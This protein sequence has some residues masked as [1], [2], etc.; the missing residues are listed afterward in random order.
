MKKYY[1]NL[2]YINNC[3]NLTNELILPVLPKNF[4]FYLQ[5]INYIKTNT[6]QCHFCKKIGEKNG[7]DKRFSRRKVNKSTYKVNYCDNIFCE[8][9]FN[10]YKKLYNQFIKNNDYTLFKNLTS[11]QL[12]Y[13]NIFINK[14]SRE[15]V[16]V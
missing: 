16:N 6:L 13:I 12:T 5:N 3:K 14:N 1:T 15:L 10:Y 2:H 7:L 4:N 9:K 8:T 11:Q